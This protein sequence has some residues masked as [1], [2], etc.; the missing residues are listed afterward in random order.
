MSDQEQKQFQFTNLFRAIRAVFDWMACSTW[1]SFCIIIFF[2]LAIHVNQLNKVPNRYLVPDASRELGA[3]AISLFETGQFANPYMIQ[4]GLTAHLPPVIPFINS[5]IYRVFGLNSSAGYVSRL[6]VIA[7]GSLLFALLP[8]FAD[9]LGLGKRAGFI[10]GLA[11][12]WLFEWRGHGEYLTGL[13]MGLILVVFLRRWTQNSLSWKGSFLLGLASGAAFH[14]QPALLPVILGC[15]AFELCWRRNQQKW[16]F[17]NII[18]LGIVLACVP[19]AWRNYDNFHALF[20]V[21]SNFGLELRLGNHEG[22]TATMEELVAKG[23]PRH[24]KANFKEV[25]LLREVGEVAYMRQARREAWEWIKTNPGDF[26]SLTLQRF[27]IL[28]TGPWHQPRAA[29]GVFALTLLAVW[30]AWRVFPS[31][32]VP[33]RALV[34][35]PLATYPLIYYFVPYLPRY[36]VPI[37]WLLFILAG[38]VIHIVFPRR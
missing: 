28:W 11:G 33:Q 18:A 21:R 14:V 13:V 32:L 27:A 17:V 15:M 1:R 4:T 6:F 7:N 24:P 23:E 38:T 34:L 37:D 25:R 19:W 8:W 2:S 5:L 20:F 10:G 30:G 12:V 3:I 22:A 35:I 16:A 9:Q 26:L 31:L 29:V 36:R